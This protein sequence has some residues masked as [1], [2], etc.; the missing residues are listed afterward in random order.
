MM[1]AGKQ[2]RPAQDTA[3]GNQRAAV[4][5]SR[6]MSNFSHTRTAVRSHFLPVQAIMPIT[7]TDNDIKE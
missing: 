4:D 2:Y 7:T 3:D 5:L 1:S 6:S